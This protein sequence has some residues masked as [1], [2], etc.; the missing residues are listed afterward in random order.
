MNINKFGA[1]A[2]LDKRIESSTL[3]LRVPFVSGA[4][5]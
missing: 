3:G 4:Q 2:V 5:N 1:D